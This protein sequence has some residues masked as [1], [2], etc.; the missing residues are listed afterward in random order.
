MYFVYI[1]ES[2]LD[3]SYYVGSTCN[4][5][6]RLERHNQGRA[7]VTKPKRPWRLVWKKSFSD[8]HEA[9]RFEYLIKKQKSRLYIKKLIGNFGPSSMVERAA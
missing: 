3:G 5:V 1:L 8:K 6:R 2:E 9:I 7:A 4:L